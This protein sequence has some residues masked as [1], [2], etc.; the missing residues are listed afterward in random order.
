MAHPQMY[1]VGDPLLVR[2]REIA[3]SFPEAQEKVAHGRPTFFTVKVF[4]YY[5]GSIKGDHQSGVLDRAVLFLPDE[6]DRD[7]LLADGRFVVPAYLGP[8]GWLALD[9]ANGSP[10]WDEVRELLDESYRRTAPRRLVEQLD[11]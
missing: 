7:G 2:L 3:L 6:Q 11:G 8:S 10:D 9:L 1:D 5:G 4:G